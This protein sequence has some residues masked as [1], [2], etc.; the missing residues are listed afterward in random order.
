MN[1]NLGNYWTSAGPYD[2]IYYYI[3][4]NVDDVRESLALMISGISVPAKIREYAATSMKM[5]TSD[6]IFSA[7]VVYGFLSY[8]SGKVCIPNKELMGKFIDMLLEK[9]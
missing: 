9:N 8:E 5:R 6:E 3:E 4:N 7:M 2:E 1:N